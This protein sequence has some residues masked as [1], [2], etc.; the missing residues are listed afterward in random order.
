MAQ[1]VVAIFEDGVFRPLGPVVFAEHEQVSLAVT[2]AVAAADNASAAAES[3]AIA[4]Q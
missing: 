2:R 1:F 3:A 4:I